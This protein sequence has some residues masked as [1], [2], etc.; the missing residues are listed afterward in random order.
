MLSPTRI[1]PENNG[2]IRPQPD[3]ENAFAKASGGSG[4][5]RTH[6]GVPPTLVFKTRALNHSATLPCRFGV[7]RRQPG[8]HTCGK[9]ILKGRPPANHGR[10]PL[11]VWGRHRLHPSHRLRKGVCLHTSRRTRWGKGWTTPGAMGLEPPARSFQSAAFRPRGS[12]GGRWQERFS[13]ISFSG[14]RR[15]AC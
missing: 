14:W 1:T 13:G 7:R 10:F 9:A 5:I 15:R 3:R 2:K 12:E 8:P 4:G 6:G 11:I